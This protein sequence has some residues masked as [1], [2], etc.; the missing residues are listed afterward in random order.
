MIDQRPADGFRVV[1]LGASAGGLEPYMEIISRLAANTGMAYIVAQH[2]APTMA[3]LLPTILAR[4]ASMPVIDIEQ[5]MRIEPDTI[6]VMAPRTDLSVEEDVF[7]VRNA[8]MV[9]GWPKNISTLLHSLAVSMGNRVVGVILSGMDSDG[10]AA[11]KIVKAAGGITFAQADAHYASMPLSALDTG[12]VDHFM[13][14][15]EIAM[16]LN[17]LNRPAVGP[18]HYSTRP[19]MVS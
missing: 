15:H 6:Y 13:S 18:L 11:L 17:R 14:A 8:P 19:H 2:R 16:A 12:H 1:C 10:A 7:I 9:S 3:E 5:G 4:M